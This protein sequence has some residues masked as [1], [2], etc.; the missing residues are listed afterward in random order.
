MEVQS[1]INES[2]LKEAR[3]YLIKPG[4]RKI[5]A[6]ASAAFVLLAAYCM[7][8]GRPSTMLLAVFA[9]VM[10]LIDVENIR[11]GKYII[12]AATFFA[13]AVSLV[14]V[15][16]LDYFKNVYRVCRIAAVILLVLAVP[17]IFMGAN[18]GFSLLWYLLLPVITLIL[19][20]M[21]FGVPVCVIYGLYITI[22]FWT[23]L[24][25]IFNY[26][27]GR[28]YRFFYPVF[29]WGFCLVVITVDIFYKNY[30]M[31]QADD[32]HELEKEVQSAVAGTKVL[33]INSVTAISR[34]LDEKDGY[35]QQHSKRVAQYSELIAQNMKSRTYTKEE[36]DIIYRSALLHD[37]GKIAVPDAVLNKPSRLTDGEYELMK[38]HTIWGKE[39]LA[40]LEFLP[41][42]DMGAAYHHE[43]FDGKGYPY[44]IKGDKIPDIVRIISAADSLDAMSSNRC[45]RRH[46]DKDY[47]ISEFEKGAGTQFDADVAQVVV[48]LIKEG[49]IIL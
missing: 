45:Y 27:Y 23:P 13:A 43:R 7:L 20:G 14:A 24:G 46:C 30:Q 48:G 8:T 38:K 37:I 19:L 44:G 34:M 9:I 26:D 29:Y 49:R 11:L 22:S 32:E 40:G 16:A 2:A 39:I 4:I 33:I 36:I 47:I 25:N 28:D 31:R 3:K 15:W 18:D 1:V 21:K 5:S 6:I 10:I 17:I 41:Q 42:A 35:T 12:G